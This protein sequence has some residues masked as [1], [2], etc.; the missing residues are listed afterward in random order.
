MNQARSRPLAV[1]LISLFFVFGATMS[2]LATFLLLVPGTILDTLW[3]LNPRARAEFSAMPHQAALLMMVIY[4]ACLAAGHGLWRCRRWGLWLAVAILIVN[5][6]GDIVTAL[7]VHD[8][9]TLIG[10]PIA[11]LMIWSLVRVRR[12]FA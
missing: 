5:T 7:V 1:T 6:C 10:P 4:M 2:A 11:G 12:V 9:R 3:R 8:W